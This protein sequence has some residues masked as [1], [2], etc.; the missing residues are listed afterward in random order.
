M[1]ECLMEKI[2]LITNIPTPYRLPLFTRLSQ[3]CSETGRSLK[4]VFCEHGY[5]RRKFEMKEDAF[6]FEHTYL[7][8]GTLSD[9]KDVEKTYFLYRGLLKLFRREKPSKIILAG[10]SPATAKAYLWNLLTGT[11][12]YIW[13]GTINKGNRNTSFHRRFFRRMMIRRAAGFI[14][15]GSEARNYLTGLGAETGRVWVAT[16]A[17]DTDFFST[18]TEELRRR[19][20]EKEQT[21]F[22]FIYIGY[23]VPRKKVEKVIEAAALLSESRKD[24]RLTIVG[25]GSSRAEL[26]KV[27]SAS[28]LS[29]RVRFEGYRQKEELPA[30]LA[31]ADAFLFQTG[32]DIWGLVLN[33]AMAAGLPVIASVN[34]G[35]TT[36]LIIDGETGFTADYDRIEETAELMNKLIENRELCRTIGSRAREFVKEKASLEKAA[37]AFVLALNTSTPTAEKK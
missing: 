24:F 9:A 25:D 23:L 13:S 10:F 3:R 22:N 16:N 33:E 27:C 29:E 35:A 20:D 19:K 32:Y 37:E 12:F 8:G 28:A 26:E 5:A 36:D 6:G 7:D 18:R 11:P 17:V 1:D 21:L 14:A 30:Y 4:V 2:L 34:A 15:Y 31:E